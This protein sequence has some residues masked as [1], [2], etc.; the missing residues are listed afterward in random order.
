MEGE[1]G[2]VGGCS[3]VSVKRSSE[4]GETWKHEMTKL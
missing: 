3:A 4:G 2:F 1:G